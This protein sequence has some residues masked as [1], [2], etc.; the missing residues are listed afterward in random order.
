MIVSSG[1]CPFFTAFLHVHSLK[2][3]ALSRR[4]FDTLG[5]AFVVVADAGVVAT[6]AAVVVVI[7]MILLR[8]SGPAY[9]SASE[10]QPSRGPDARSGRPR[11]KGRNTFA[12]PL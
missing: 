5:R 4:H 7:R 1:E 2:F 10:A 12:P 11:A 8:S 6:M 3:A 9:R